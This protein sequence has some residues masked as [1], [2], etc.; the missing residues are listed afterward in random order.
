MER[1]ARIL[2]GIFVIVLVLVSAPLRNSAHAGG[3]FVPKPT[4]AEPQEKMEQKRQKDML[5]AKETFAEAVLSSRALLNDTDM[6]QLR[7]HLPYAKAIMVFPSLLSGGFLLGLKGGTG[8]LIARNGDG[9]SDAGFV[10]LRAVSFGLQI[11]GEKSESIFLIMTEKGLQSVTS[12][13]FKLGADASVA[14]LGAGIGATAATTTAA[15]DIYAF[16]KAAGAFIGVSFEGARL[17]QNLE[18]NQV[19]YGEQLTN[20]RLTSR[21]NGELSAPLAEVLRNH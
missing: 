13:S 21:V 8:V 4:S 2:G 17:E 6:V 19:F 20:E 15:T 7:K 1:S 16:G 18:L 3:D 12:G 10:D 5:R 9:W 14:I 11:G